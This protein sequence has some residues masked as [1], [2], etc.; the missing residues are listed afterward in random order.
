MTLFLIPLVEG[1]YGPNYLVMLGVFAGE[2]K[3][4]EDREGRGDI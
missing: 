2:E 3:E 4:E 1:E